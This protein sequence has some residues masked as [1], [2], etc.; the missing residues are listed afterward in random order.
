MPLSVLIVPDKFKGTLTAD[1]AARAIARGW[2]RARPQD[3]IDVV[4]M[5]DGGDGFGPV[6]GRLLEAQT[7]TTTTLDAAHR[8]SRAR[9]WWVSEERTAV[10]ESARVIGLARLPQG[11]FHPFQL[12]TTGLGRV[13]IAVARQGARRCII[14]VGGSATN[15]GGFGFARS[16][17]WRFLDRVGRLIDRW[18]ELVRLDRIEP[19]T[20]SEVRKLKVTVAV[21]VENLLLGP[22]G[23]SHVY[24]PQKGLRPRDIPR[25]EANLRRLAHVWRRQFGQDPARRPGSGAAGGLGFGLMAFLGANTISGSVLFARY[26]RLE[27]RLTKADLVITGEGCIDPSSLMGKGVGFISLRCRSHG[28]PC[29]GLGGVLKDRAALQRGFTAIHG[30]TPELTTPD[31]ALTRPALW[32]ARLSARVARAWAKPHR[33]PEVQPTVGSV[34]EGSLGRLGGKWL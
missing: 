6:L 21:D 20:A 15:D 4:P 18:T 14:G 32:L 3:R 8:R 16:L 2:R 10:I 34:P 13:L 30:L 33:G 22:R 26:A 28:V 23:A 24:G 1:R 29:L 17:G 11:R 12:D 27:Q 9:W 5:S 19:A 7:R 25:A 31:Q